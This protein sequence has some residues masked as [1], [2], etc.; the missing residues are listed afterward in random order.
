MSPAAF[1]AKPD[2]ADIEMMDG[3]MGGGGV[4]MM[5]EP[6]SEKVRL[7]VCFGGG[8]RGG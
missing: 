7:C 3:G 4:G 1:Q 2:V 8:G 6:P 5:G